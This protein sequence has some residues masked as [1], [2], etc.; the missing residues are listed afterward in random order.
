MK[1]QQSEIV[2][3]IQVFKCPGIGCPHFEGVGGTLNQLHT[4][5]AFQK[6]PGKFAR[7]VNFRFPVIILSAAAKRKKHAHKKY[8]HNG[9]TILY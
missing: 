8:K 5:G 2:A 9:Q 3:N 6:Q 4:K 7:F 1:V